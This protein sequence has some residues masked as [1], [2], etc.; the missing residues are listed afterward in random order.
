VALERRRVMLAAPDAAVQVGLHRGGVLVERARELAA[1]AAGDARTA[2]SGG[3]MGQ[4]PAPASG[5]LFA[6]QFVYYALSLELSQL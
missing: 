2:H 4:L 6:V 5:A 1:L 3:E